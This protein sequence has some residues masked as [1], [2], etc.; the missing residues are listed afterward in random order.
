M[1]IYD[2]REEG[3]AADHDHEG[4]E[5]SDLITPRVDPFSTQR[6]IDQISEEEE[7][8]YHGGERVAEGVGVGEER[9]LQRALELAVDRSEEAYDKIN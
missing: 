1:A 7:E 8:G 4:T 2:E 9:H 5:E 3:Q 6:A